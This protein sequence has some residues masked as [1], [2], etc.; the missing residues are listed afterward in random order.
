MLGKALETPLKIAGFTVDLAGDVTVGVAPPAD[1]AE[2]VTVGVASS[3]DLSGYVTVVVA[4]SADLAED[5][6]VGMASSADLTVVASVGVGSTVDLADVVTAG[7]ASLADLAGDVS[8]G[9]SLADIAEVAPSAYYD[10]D[11][12]ASVTSMEQCGK[13]D[14]V[15]SDY[16][17]NYDDYHY[18][19]LYDDR[20]DYYELDDCHTEEYQ[21]RDALPSDV[22]PPRTTPDV[23][24]AERVPVNP[25]PSLP[26]AREIPTADC[27]L[28]RL[29][30]TANFSPADIAPVTCSDLADPSPACGFSRQCLPGFAHRPLDLFASIR[31][32]LAHRMGLTVQ[33]LKSFIGATASRV[34]Y[35]SSAPVRLVA[36][37]F[38]AGSVNCRL[39][40]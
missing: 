10:C 2:V 1:L 8:A 34:P 40:F 36:G 32:L 25:R 16:D 11:V 27:H 29:R 9:R 3:A 17:E 6:T 21:E 14:V 7:V 31:L 13:C 30:D 33:D 38:P 12:T 4:S 24:S 35:M 22:V 23:S 20:P 15:R 5:V 28:A 26:C 39:L 19:C 18:D 37:S